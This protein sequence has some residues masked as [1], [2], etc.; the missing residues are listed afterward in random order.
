[1]DRKEKLYPKVSSLEWIEHDLKKYMK[2]ILLGKIDGMTT[3][4]KL[5]GLPLLENDDFDSMM[6]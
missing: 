3:D 6:A 2:Q 4:R 1:M 5:L